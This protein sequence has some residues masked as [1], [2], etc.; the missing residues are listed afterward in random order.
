MKTYTK[1][2]SASLAVL[3]LAYSSKA[4]VRAENAD[5]SARSAI[6]VE[7]SSGDVIYEKNAHEKLP[8][9]STTKIMTAVVA[10]ENAKLDAKVK[11]SPR[12]CGIEGSSIYLEKDEVLTVEELLYAIMLES[13][14]DAASAL[15]IHVAGSEEK[16]AQ[17]MNETALRIGMTESHFTNPHGLDNAEHYSTAA[18]MAK[19]AVY[20]LGNEKFREIVSTVKRQIPAGD[21]EG[22]RVLVN[23]NRLLRLSDEVIGVKTGF[24]KRSGRCLVSAAERGGVRVIAVTLSDPNDWKDHLAMHDVGLSAYCTFTLA[25]C[26]QF[27]LNLP[28]VGDPDGFITVTNHDTLKLTAKAETEFSHVIEA[29]RLVFPPVTT[30]EPLGRVVFYS[31]EDVVGEVSLYP[32]EDVPP[33]PEEK[34]F[35]N[36]ILDIFR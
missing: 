1:I 2:I 16:F 29:D 27:T 22:V 20:A 15:A 36:K 35:G 3:A 10:L 31:G 5:V 33:L 4:L 28:C 34:S 32:I 18:D 19:L 26:E 25:D 23:H 24:T 14:N 17:L 11:I 21:D 30:E 12:A 9:A 13:A 8:I 6:L 7:A